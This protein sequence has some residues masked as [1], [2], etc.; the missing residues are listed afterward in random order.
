MSAKYKI[1]SHTL[2]SR[3]TPY[4]EEITGDLQCG[5]R[6]CKSTTDHIFCI[7]QIL[8]KKWEYGEVGHRLFIDFKKA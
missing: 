4:V 5:F 7:Y 8:Q 2:L 1:L 6:R 3:L